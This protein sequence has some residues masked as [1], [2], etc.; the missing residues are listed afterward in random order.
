MSAN[1]MEVA[2]SV[3]GN[4][5]GP[6]KSLAN[7]GPYTPIASNWYKSLP[8]AFKAQISETIKVFYLPINPQNLTITTYYATNVIST[9]YGTVEEHSEQRYFDIVIQGTTG[10]AP[11]YVA[12]STSTPESFSGRENYST[13]SLASIAGGFFSKTLGKLD[14]ALN[15]AKDL[16]NIWDSDGANGFEPGVYFDN[17][18]Y[19]A[20]HNLY[21]FLLEYKKSAAAG[22]TTSA[23]SMGTASGNNSLLYFVN[24]KDNNQYSCAV[25][26][27]TLERSAEN[28]MLYNYV[29]RLRAYNLTGI[30][31][32]D[33][34]MPSES[35]ISNR[36]KDL[37]LDG[38][39]SIFAKLKNT[40]TKSKGLANS[41]TGAFSTLG[42]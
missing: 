5:F 11:Q 24:Y 16:K 35:A 36:I 9:L 12:A 4:L 38:G 3:A 31:G 20:F 7:S 30:V 40:V 23:S 6:P 13:F 25:Q 39:P 8:Y 32:S 34:M 29:I 15:Q 41:V 37:G 28:P 17:S 22:K 18:G 2:T 1:P 33:Q 26:T 21:K 19:T 42:A 27:F 14:N 10:F